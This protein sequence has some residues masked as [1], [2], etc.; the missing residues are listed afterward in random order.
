MGKFILKAIIFIVLLIAILVGLEYIAQ[1]TPNAYKHKEEFITNN[2][3]SINTLILGSSHTFYGVNPEYLENK[4][5]NLANVSQDLKFDLYLLSRYIDKC[6]KLKT[7]VVSISYFTLYETPLDKEEEKFRVKFYEHYMGY[8]DTTLYP[9]E[10]LE[11]YDIN[12]FQEK[13]V[14]HINELCGEKSDYGYDNNGWATGY[15]SSKIDANIENDAIK[16]VARHTPKGNYYIEE[17][18][19]YLIQIAKLCHKHNVRLFFITTPTLPA[20][21]NKIDKS[22][23]N[24]T[25]SVVNDICIEY[26]ASYFNYLDDDRF[27]ISDFFDIDHLCH[28]G[29][30]KFSKILREDMFE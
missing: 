25:K 7:L 10:K 29:A 22:R 9:F 13:I 18:K 26:N 14:K 3:D 16:T 11:I 20:Y 30:E 23:W 8:N 5:F 6:K 12:I 28:K 19:E 4:S 15:N 27:D 21:Y 17:N 1:T 2:S 24:Y